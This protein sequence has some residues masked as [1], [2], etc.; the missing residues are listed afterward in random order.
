MVVSARPG[1]GI[2]I[3]FAG[4]PFGQVTTYS[5]VE[6]STPVAPDDTTGGYG[7]MTVEGRQPDLPRYLRGQLVTLVDGAQGETAGIVRSMNGNGF[8][9]QFQG[10]SYLAK[11]AVK[12]QAQP[13]TGTLGGALNGYL[14]LCGINGGIVIDPALADRHVDLLGWNGVVYDQLKKLATALG[15]EMAFVSD[16]VVFRPLRGRVAVNYRDADISWGMDVTQFAQTVEGYSYSN[17]YRADALAYPVGGWNEDVTVYSVEAGQTQEIELPLEASLSSVQ[18]PTCVE[19]VDRNYATSSVYAVAGNDGLPVKPAQWAAGGGK[20]EVE[21]GE[22]TRTL[23]VKITASTETQ[24]APYRIA[25][26]A[27]TS[28]YYSSLRI[29]GTGVFYKK[30]LHTL[31]AHIDKDE[32][33]EELGATVDNEFIST[34]DDLHHA[35]LWTAVRYSLPRLTINVTTKG[36][37]RRDDNGSYRYP[38]IG[39]LRD[40]YP[41]YTIQEMYDE[42]G[43]TIGDWNDKLFEAVRGDFENQAF[44]NIAGAR[45]LYDNCWYRIRSATTTPGQITYSAE[46]DNTIGDVY[47]T[48]ETIGEWNDRWAGKTIGDVN[49]VPLLGLK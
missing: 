45:V 7:Q 36:I 40:T 24:Y 42:L 11:T 1:T 9:I 22:D 2:D 41:G 46:W 35:L 10:D 38:T 43:P 44:G 23:K 30:E 13:Y 29:V 48:G 8:K 27:G 28:D 33:P 17:E 39:Y 32:A 6:D 20:L 31:P 26:S 15:F 12:R 37:N 19:F 21:I 47:H 4:V 3:R 5:V 49:E 25:V 16:N 18:Q 34:P 14:A